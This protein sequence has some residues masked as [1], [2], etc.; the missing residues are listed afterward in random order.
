METEAFP[1]KKLLSLVLIGIL[2][3]GCFAGCSGKNT[4]G[5]YT[6]RA[7][8]TTYLGSWEPIWYDN[9]QEKAVAALLNCP[10]WESVIQDT[11]TGAYQWVFLGAESLEDVTEQHPEDLTKYGGEAV[12]EIR[13]RKEMCWEDGTLITADTYLYSLDRLVR[14]R[15]RLV[16]GAGALAGAKEYLDKKGTFEET[17]GLYAVDDYTLR[18]V[19]Q[20]KTTKQEL[21]LA[22][23]EPFLL[24]PDLHE[25]N[26]SRYAT[27]L[28]HTASCG[29]YRLTRADNG[30]LELVQNERYWEYREEN[31]R[32]VSTTSFQVDGKNLPQYQ[33]TTIVITK[34]TEAEAKQAYQEGKIDYWDA[35]EA[36]SISLLTNEDLYRKGQ[37]F[38]LRLFFNTTSLEEC[39]SEYGNKN[40]IV[41]SN[42][43]FRKAMSL[44]VDRADWVT[45]TEGY[46]PAL[47][48][49][50]DLSYYNE[51][52]QY[53]DSLAGK[54]ALCGLYG[55]DAAAYSTLTGYDLAQAKT[56][57]EESCRELVAAGLYKEGENI[58]IR[59]AWKNGQITQEDKAQAA[60][61]EKY[62]QAAMEGSGFGKLTLEAVDGGGDRYNAVA[63]GRFAI[64][65]GA[66]GGNVF[67][68]YS[69]L[70]LY[71]DGNCPEEACW[72]P[73][74]ERLMLSVEGKRISKTWSWWAQN[75]CD[76]GELASLR[77]EDRLA[78]LATLEQKLLE[79]YY[80]IPLATTADCFL[81]SQKL[82][83]YTDDYNVLYGFGGLRLLQY[84]YTD[85]QWQ[86]HLETPAK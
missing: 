49:I 13:L 26:H 75:L 8:V 69:A 18:Y 82:H 78:L 80:T 38:V 34:M 53:R 12:F 45:A 1:L 72:N 37:S 51:T 70:R 25:A 24:K 4:E 52:S 79:K 71:C 43:K 36:E 33:T 31:G 11:K 67:D 48:L 28:E 47:G 68:P 17:V 86:A 73:W 42:E 7:A 29:P 10:L 27:N 23:T 35:G 2:L 76:G 62:L 9:P 22:L 77:Q 39:D 54:E 83:C 46:A 57:M 41:L 85:A 74:E 30:V 32:L 16:E 14:S 61:L 66:W 5:R 44:A 21:M 81:L 6:L 64:G 20:E 56:L 65:L 63:N 84:D 55:V 58:H 50:N 15:T 60:L 40:S 59:I 19:C 3:L